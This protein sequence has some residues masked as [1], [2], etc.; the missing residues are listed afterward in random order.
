MFGFVSV[1][2]G[3]DHTLAIWDLT[4]TKIKESIEKSRYYNGKNSDRA[5]KTVL[6]CF[7]IYRTRE[8]HTNYVDCVQWFNDLILSKVFLLLFV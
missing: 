2:S 6:Q 8:I 4:V 5:F 7:P 3:M 1:S